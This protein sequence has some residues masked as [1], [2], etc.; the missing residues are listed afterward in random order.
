ML[1]ILLRLVW[2]NIVSV[3]ST[4]IHQVCL[5]YSMLSMGRVESVQILNAGAHKKSDWW[6]YLQKPN[7]EQWPDRQIYVKNVYG[8]AQL[9]IGT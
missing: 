5:E 8:A 4:C 7:S 3:N 1:T 9:Q 6:E 2:T